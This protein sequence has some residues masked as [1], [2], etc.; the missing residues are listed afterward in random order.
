MLAKT[1]IGNMIMTLNPRKAMTNNH[2][3]RVVG[4]EITNT[5]ENR[6]TIKKHKIRVIES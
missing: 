1:R 3:I 2:A 5:S 6:E 4:M